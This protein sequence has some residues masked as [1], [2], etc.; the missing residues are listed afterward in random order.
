ML[1]EVENYRGRQVLFA[2]GGDDT[3]YAGTGDDEVQGQGGDDKLYGQDGNDIL[4]GGAGDDT[5]EGGYGSDTYVYNKGDGHDVINN[6]SH[7]GD[8]ETDVLKFGEGI[9][10]EDLE[11]TRRGNDLTLS[12]KDGSGSVRIQEHFSSDYT[13]LDEVEFSD[14]TKWSAED[15]ASRVVTYGTDEGE[16]LGKN[17]NFNGNDR[18]YAGGGNDKL[19]GQSGDDVLVGGT[20]D[21]TLE[22]G[23]GNDVY[24]YNRGDGHDVIN[25]YSHYGDQE[26]DVLKFGE[27]ISAEDLEVTRRGNDLTLSLKDGSGSVRVQEHFRNDYYELDEVEFS[28]GTK[29]SAE[30]IA[31][32]AV[33]RGT[34]TNA[35]A[36]SEPAGAPATPE[37]FSAVS[38]LSAM[39][40]ADARVLSESEIEESLAVLST[41]SFMSELND[42]TL[43]GWSGS[44]S[45]AAMSS[46]PSSP[47]DL[48]AARLGMDV[49]LAGLSFETPNSGLVCDALLSGSSGVDVVKLSVST[50]TCLEKHFEK[51][52]QHVE[53]SRNR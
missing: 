30:D 22:G 21:D 35:A 31:S 41:P 3:V 7:Y 51:G 1:G 44:S 28:D 17:G 53:L 4:V 52:A 2:G 33:T 25:N 37:A 10:A 23:Y 15:V 14:G 34:D 6:Y 27:G 39:S 48:E 43:G 29:W 12:L 8:R 18:I 46:E 32:R 38:P 49:A 50:E 19:Y 36:S 40:G 9:S 24:V 26:T 45:L 11:V 5:L 13:K 16:E 47:V 42:K 20:G